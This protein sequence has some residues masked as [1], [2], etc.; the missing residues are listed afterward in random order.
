MD[1]NVSQAPFRQTLEDKRMKRDCM[2]VQTRKRLPTS[3]P[4]GLACPC[5]PTQQRKLWPTDAHFDSNSHHCP[6][7]PSISPLDPCLTNARGWL[8]DIDKTG[9]T[10]AAV[11]SVLGRQLATTLPTSRT[12][13]TIN[14]L[15]IRTRIRETCPGVVSAL[16]SLP[17]TKKV[18]CC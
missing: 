11:S 1:E 7:K 18:T 3:Y 4:N 13:L 5:D 8:T 17:L 14:Y 10:K 2:K 12:W 16:E 6:K 15:I 9:K